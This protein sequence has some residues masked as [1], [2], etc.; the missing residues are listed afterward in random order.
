MGVTPG[1]ATIRAIRDGVV[2]EAR[3]MVA[4]TPVTRIDVA[5]SRVDVP[6]Y[7][8]E[9]VTAVLYDARG[10]KLPP[11]PVSWS[12]SPSWLLVIDGN[13]YMVGVA[14]GTGTITARIDQAV[15]TATYTVVNPCSS[16]RLAPASPTFVLGAIYQLSATF[17]DRTANVIVPP[18]VV[19]TSSNTAVAEVGQ[20]GLV[21]P[22]AVGVTT[23]TA[24]CGRTAAATV[25]RISR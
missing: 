16:G 13:G 12:A 20:D 10:N 23:V 6:W 2:G 9:R 21:Y 24:S 14:E 3:V 15:G 11:R 17:S 8:R 25:V 22:R 7:G 5:P 4:W 18:A 19:W 1:S